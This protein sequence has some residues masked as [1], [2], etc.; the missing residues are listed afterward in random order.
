[1]N[2]PS[3]TAKPE[4]YEPLQQEL[5]EKIF[6]D[7]PELDPA[8]VVLLYEGF[9]HFLDILD[10]RDDVPGLA[11]IDFMKL[12]RE[13]DEFASKMN[14]Y[15]SSEDDRGEAVL[16]CL[17]RIF[18][19]RRGI[20][21]PPLHAAVIGS[22]RTNAHN[23]ATHGAGTMVVE[24]NNRITEITAIPQV[25]LACCA[26]RLNATGMDAVKARRQLYLRWRVPCV[27]LSIFMSWILLHF[28][29]I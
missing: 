2:P 18:S 22:A 27:G 1:M 15:Y 26:A 10:G 20:K 13:V 8:S 3:T 29:V 7:R 25:Q 6:G 28:M 5:S 16:P 21:I 4:F 24:F 23:V 12:H 11:D 14:R 19:A 9:G 17:T